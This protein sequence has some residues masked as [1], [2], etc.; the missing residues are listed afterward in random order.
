MFIVRTIIVGWNQDLQKYSLLKSDRLGF[1]VLKVLTEN[2]SLGHQ[3]LNI[4]CYDTEK[5]PDQGALHRYVVSFLCAASNKKEHYEN[6]K[7]LKLEK[8]D[9]PC[10]R[11]RV[12][13]SDRERAL[14]YL[15]ACCRVMHN[16]GVSVKPSLIISNSLE[17]AEILCNGL[18]WDSP[19]V[20][21][22]K[23]FNN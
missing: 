9:V 13:F 3:I 14:D 23:C 21:L 4:Q 7:M 18:E 19:C 22:R 20:D 12:A 16:Q 10:V 15:E 6:E 17:C 11:V 2:Q 1:D 5:I 8:G